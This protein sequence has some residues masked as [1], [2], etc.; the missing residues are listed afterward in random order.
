MA[1]KKHILLGKIIKTH[2]FEGAVTVKVEKNFSENIPEPESV[3]LEIEGRPVPFFIEWA[4]QSDSN[5]LRLKFDGYD[6]AAMVKEF[7]GCTIYLT[8]SPAELITDHDLAELNGY[9]VFTSDGRK[10]GVIKKLIENTSQFLL[11]IQADSGKEFLVP[12]HEDLIDAIDHT[13]KTIIMAIP[14]G[15]EDLN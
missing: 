8:D 6:T 3:F 15:L 1:Y 10:A 9:T 2:G 11:S 13:D 7:A 14:E 12:L 5:T 4:E